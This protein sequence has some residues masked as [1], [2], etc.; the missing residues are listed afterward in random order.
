MPVPARVNLN[1]TD[2]AL[3]ACETLYYTFDALI[4]TD[5]LSGNNIMKPRGQ[6]TLFWD[7]AI[8]KIGRYEIPSPIHT[9]SETESELFDHM[10]RPVQLDNAECACVTAYFYLD[11]L[12]GLANQ[13]HLITPKLPFLH[14]AAL[15]PGIEWAQKLSS[16]D[17][18]T[19]M[20]ALRGGM[21]EKGHQVLN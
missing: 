18:S 10:D 17:R 16:S 5:G 15:S 2:E 13:W 21:S 9:I 19:I 20:S 11:M 7:W 3:M 1:P 6:T 12:F 8:V 14:V 4:T